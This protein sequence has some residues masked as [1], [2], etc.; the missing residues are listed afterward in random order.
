VLTLLAIRP[1]LEKSQLFVAL[2]SGVV[3]AGFISV[4]GMW[5]SST[6][7]GTDLAQRA[8]DRLPEQNRKGD[9]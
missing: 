9:N 8:M 1:D 4:L 7:A 5:T 2:A 3:G 6:K